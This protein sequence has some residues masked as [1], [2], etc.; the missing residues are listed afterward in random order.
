VIE[1]YVEPNYE[2]EAQMADPTL[3][4]VVSV[5]VI[6]LLQSSIERASTSL[7]P[8]SNF[9]DETFFGCNCLRATVRERKTHVDNSVAFLLIYLS[10]SAFCLSIGT[11]ADE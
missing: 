5:L 7:F 8:P 10:L 1:N 2:N 4:S 11:G 3:L 9:P 6:R